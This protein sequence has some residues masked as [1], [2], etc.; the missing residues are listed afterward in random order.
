MPVQRSRI[1]TDRTMRVS[2]GRERKRGVMSQTV[3]TVPPTDSQGQSNVMIDMRS[4][5]V[6]PNRL[7][8]AVLALAEIASFGWGIAILASQR[9]QHIACM[10]SVLAGASRRNVGV[11]RSTDEARDWLETRQEKED[12]DLALSA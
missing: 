11:F 3:L 10:V 6:N 5:E 1:Q 2:R 9:T 12:P 7:A 8:P 4:L